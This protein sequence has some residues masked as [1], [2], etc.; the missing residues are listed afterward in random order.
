VIDQAAATDEVG[1]PAQFDMAADG[2]NSLA[3]DT[4]GLMIRN[5]NNIGAALDR[6]ASDSGTYYVLAYRP[7]DASFD[8]K[9]RQIEVRV[10]RPDVQVRARRGYLAIEPARLLTPQPIKAAERPASPS[11]PTPGSTPPSTPPNVV[12]PLPGPVT[13]TV[14]SGAATSGAREMRLRPDAVERVKEI[15]GSHGKD[16]GSAAAKGWSAYERGDV[17]SAVTAFAAAAAEPNVRPW[18][19]YALGL[20]YTALGRHADAAAAWERVILAAP[21]FSAVYIDLADAYLQQSDASRALQVLRDGS[22]RWPSDPEFHNAIGVIHVRR[23]ALDDGIAAFARAAEVAPEEPLAYF[24]LGRA[25]QI[26]FSRDTRYIASQ[27]RWIAPE[28]DRQK[29]IESYQKYLTLGGPYATQAAD[30]I[31]MLEWAK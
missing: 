18:V 22:R 25:Y 16:T 11:E 26:R 28:G 4:G 17:E 21:D 24:N 23:G 31:R 5:Q 30:A 1:G 20:S 15:A 13:G 9:Y 6:I 14:V 29:A 27:R 8:G 19:V 3:V 2:P 7:T 12:E 10:T